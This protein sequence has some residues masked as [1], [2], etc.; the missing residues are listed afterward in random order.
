MT[1]ENVYQHVLMGSKSFSL[2]FSVS[3]ADYGQGF[4]RGES[5]IPLL[6][7]R[8]EHK[9]DR[10]RTERLEG[11]EEAGMHLCSIS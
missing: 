3:K 5:L 6:F 2:P 11:V 8:T 10:H 4:I 1:S 7:S 9:T